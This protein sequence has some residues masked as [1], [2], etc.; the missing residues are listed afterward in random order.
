MPTAMIS[1]ARV[2]DDGRFDIQRVEIHLGPETEVLL[3]TGC[4]L[5]R[6]VGSGGGGDVLAE[7]DLVFNDWVGF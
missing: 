6:R 5:D 4:V 3:Y 7:G 1:N 2:C